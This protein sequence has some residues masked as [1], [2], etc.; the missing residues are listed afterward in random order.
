MPGGSPRPNHRIISVRRSHIINRLLM[1]V[2]VVSIADDVHVFLTDHFTHV[3]LICC[4]LFNKLEVRWCLADKWNIT[5]AITISVI[6][7]F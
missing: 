2:I 7:H 5:T 4:R 6:V 1:I 3:M